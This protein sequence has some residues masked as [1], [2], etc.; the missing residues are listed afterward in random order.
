[1]SM[2]LKFMETYSP[3]SEI[4]IN[5]T[6]SLKNIKTILDTKEYTAMSIELTRGA[7]IQVIL[8]NQ[9]PNESQ[10]HS[11]EINGK[12]TRWTGPYLIQTIK[13]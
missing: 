8:S 2:Q 5:A 6:S 10:K 13:E 3:V 11:V 1:M 7:P 9:N 12:T 4:A